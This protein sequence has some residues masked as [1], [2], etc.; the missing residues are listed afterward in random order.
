MKKI[1]MRFFCVSSVVFLFWNF[2]CGVAFSGMIADF[3]SN[4]THN[5]AENRLENP[6][7]GLWIT[8]AHDHAEPQ[9]ISLNTGAGANGEPGYADISVE[10]FGD[11]G[12][13]KSYILYD[14]DRYNTLTQ[15]KNC[16]RMVLYTKLPDGDFTFHLGTYTK[17]PDI[18]TSNLGSH[19]YHYFKLKGNNNEYWTKM[20]INQH[21]QHRTSIKSPPDD[22]PTLSRGWNYFDGMCRMYHAM[23]TSPWRDNMSLFSPYPVA[24]DQ[25]EFFNETRPENTYSINSMAV[26]YFGEGEFNIDWRSFSQYDLHNELFEIKYSTS[27]INT[28]ADYANASLVPGSP[29]RG[30]GQENIGRRRNYYRANFVIDVVPDTRYYF[31]IKDLYPSHPKEFTRIDYVVGEVGQINRL[32]EENQRPQANPGP[33]QNVTDNGNDGEMV[34]LDGSGSSDPD[35]TIRSY[36]WKE[37]NTQIAIGMNPEVTLAVGTHTI[38][39]V[40]T[41]D[42]GAQDD[43]T[44]NIVVHDGT[45]VGPMCMYIEAE[46]GTIVSPMVIG[47]DPKPVASGG[48]YVYAPSAVGNTTKPANEA[49]YSI[50]VPR[51]GEYYLWLRMYG[52]S[53]TNDAMYIGFNGNFD[54]V[55]PAQ[56]SEYEW[57]RVETTHG[58]GDFSH[59][60]SA[61]SNQINIGYGEEL[62]RA[63]M[64]FVT[65][66]PDCIPAD[67][68]DNQ[69]S[70]PTGLR[71]IH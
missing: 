21:P 35:G 41:D 65:D 25:I 16:N 2:L 23:E 27:P 55:Y 24:I 15:S 14:H 37:G 59:R 42:L 6:A 60:L 44:V 22:N 33:D 46:S 67:I 47:N 62:A 18:R 64:I 26:T 3:G 34:I 68:A 43:D 54:R 28:E 17:D 63:D 30:W 19:Y 45:V 39:L 29:S 48:K 71:V 61:G 66:D 1:T 12:G 58:S 50:S 31:A 10:G 20:V 8:I 40:V 57:V 51:D 49:A 9:S 38:T 52:P 11:G 5:V 4:W 70:A 13:Y 56:T 7:T 53:S 36:L 32:P 69:M